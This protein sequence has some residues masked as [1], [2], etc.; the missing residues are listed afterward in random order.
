MT[1]PLELSSFKA[2]GQL[3]RGGTA[4]VEKVFAGEFNCLAALKYPIE[5]NDEDRI[6][7]ESL[8]RREELLL[9][10]IRFPGIVRLLKT[11]TS[12]PQYLLLELCEGPTLE[13]VGRFD[14]IRVAINL[15]SAVAVNLEFLRARGIIHGDLKPDNIFLPRDWQESVS[16]RLFYLKLS[17]FSLGRFEHEADT[18]RV[19]LGTM[20]YMAP[21]TIVDSSVSHVSDLFALGV[22]AYQMLTGKHP[23]IEENAD[24][25]RINARVQ[26]QEPTPLTALRSDIPS[27]LISIVMRLLSKN[28]D[29]RPAT[30]WDVCL[31]LRDA[32]ADYPFEK[33]LRPS[34]LWRESSHKDSLA[35][36]L[37]VREAESRQLERITEGDNHRLRL[38]ATVNFVRGN[39]RYTTTGFTLCGRVYLPRAFRRK[40]LRRFEYA[41]LSDQ[42]A[43]IIAALAGGPDNARAMGYAAAERLKNVPTLLYDLLPHLLHQGTVR[44]ISGRLAAKAELAEMHPLA[45]RLN[46]QAGRLEAA[47]RCGYQAAIALNKEN[48]NIE[49][50][51]VLDSVIDYGR[52]T[53]REFLIRH[54]AKTKGDILKEQG[55]TGKAHKVYDSVIAMYFDHPND[56]L[57]AETYKQL[58]DLYKLKQRSAEGLDA[59]SMAL[60]I[61]EDLNDELEISHTLNNLGNIHWV[62]GEHAKALSHY[63]Q[64]LRI[65]RRLDARADMA[66]SLSNAGTIYI[67]VGRYQRGIRLLQLSLNL[68]QEIG[69]RGEIARSM[70]NLGWVQYLQGAINEAVSNLTEA[71]RINRSIGS[72]REMLNNIDSIVQILLTTGRLKE[73]LTHLKEGLS[74]ADSL[75]DKPRLGSFS[76][77]MAA[78]LLRM[79]RVAD[80]EQYLQKADEMISE[81]DDHE[82]EIGLILEQ[83]CLKLLIG[84]PTQALNLATDARTKA[85]QCGDQAHELDA[86][87]LLTQLS[88]DD[89]AHQRGVELAGQ[90]QAR[91]AAT[92]LRLNRL[93]RLV[94][95]GELD[96]ARRCWSEVGPAIDKLTDDYELA[97]LYNVAAEYMMAT[98]NINRAKNYLNRARQ[99]SE[100]CGIAAQKIR[101]LTMLGQIAFSERDFEISYRNYRLALS[102]CKEVAAKIRNAEDLTTFQSQRS[103]E[104]LVEEIRRLSKVLGQKK[105]GQDHSLS[106]QKCLKV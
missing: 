61:Y 60:K 106:S 5:S 84:D 1:N 100:A 83:A 13:T 57:L 16:R 86:I 105:R 72:Q 58:G 98:D 12:D 77:S 48:Q 66:S 82:L 6:D 44:R 37:D 59:L 30:A 22:V 76:K 28:P 95:S 24:P 41:T 36:M 87:L 64:A 54:L 46:V 11:A 25:V 75:G 56:K 102:V 47:E 10:D 79:G 27:D 33:A 53:K 55:E 38:L 52:L 70:N 8:A 23:F 94:N 67:V 50:L 20:G 62:A 63:R 40:A 21:E 80:A 49:A 18:D 85:V 2:M 81:I 71:L 9:K 73:A 42:K 19:G 15:L 90:I 69:N 34:H 68:K 103:I 99:H 65:Q 96:Q 74:L 88:D 31:A 14:D 91:H 35:A 51:Q 3:G 89:T 45:A 39:L 93:E 101:S 92:I 26:E 43:M 17:D 32:G 4:R 104:F 78:V 29:Q 7:F 97:R